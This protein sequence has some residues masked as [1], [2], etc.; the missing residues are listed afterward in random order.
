MIKL[1]RT[2]LFVI[3]LLLTAAAVLLVFIR[4]VS[5][6]DIPSLAT[7]DIDRAISEKENEL[8]MLSGRSGEEE[9][10]IAAEREILSA[11]KAAGDV[12]VLG[13]RIEASPKG[14]VIINEKEGYR[15]TLPL[16]LVLARSVEGEHL[17]FHDPAVMCQGDPSCPPVLRIDVAA[18][19]PTRLPLLDWLVHE[20]TTADEIVYSP[21]EMLSING[22]TVAKVTISLPEIFDGYDYYWAHGDNIY[23]LQ[24]ARV[25]DGAYKD[26][27]YSLMVATL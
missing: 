14:K 4:Q 1:S 27:I 18:E 23:V 7:K 6:T 8:R 17:E 12:A 20:E 9:A 16:P 25:Y 24:I 21:R 10:R 5:P 19:N 26:A 15:I 13:V 2:S 22:A 3:A 11:T